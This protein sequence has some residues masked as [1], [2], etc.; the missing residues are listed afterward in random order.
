M[1]PRPESDRRGRDVSE[2]DR[3]ENDDREVGA[4]RLSSSVK[5][6]GILD[7][8]TYTIAYPVRKNGTRSRRPARPSALASLHAGSGAP[9]MPRSR[10][11]RVRLQRTAPPTKVRAAA[12][13]RHH[14][15]DGDDDSE[16]HDHLQQRPRERTTHHELDVTGGTT[17]Q[18][19][20]TTDSHP[21]VSMAPSGLLTEEDHLRPPPLFRPS[22]TPSGRTPEI[23]PDSPDAVGHNRGLDQVRHGSRGR[24]RIARHLP[25][26]VCQ[27]ET[28]GRATS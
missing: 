13:Q 8:S 21:A 19:E 25:V 14:V 10:R 16:G 6:P 23:S 24:D 15:I 11:R 7:S 2:T 9:A 4:V 18:R 27:D 1:P 12:H 22:C 3:A 5:A 26:S 28:T 17:I 20:R